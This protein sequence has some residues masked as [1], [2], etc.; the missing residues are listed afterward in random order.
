MYTVKKIPLYHIG[1]FWQIAALLS[2]CGDDMQQKYGLLHWKNSHFK[3]FLIAYYTA[4]KNTVYAV[5][6]ANRAMVA[7]F[8]TAFRDEALHFG[9]LA[10]NP[11]KAGIGIGGFC[12]SYMEDMAKKE[13]LSALICEVYEKSEHAIAFY[14]KRGFETVGECQTRK[15]RELL[16]K[17]DL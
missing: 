15:Y 10:V 3:S 2:A 4:L 13:N 11:H 16:L 14:R 6:D 8:Q 5:F 1:A 7:T 12:L 17:K 9:K